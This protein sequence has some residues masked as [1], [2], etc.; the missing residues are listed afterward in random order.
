MVAHFD[1]NKRINGIICDLCGKVCIDTFEYYSG[2]FDFISVDRNRTAQGPA[3]V[4]ERFMDVDFCKDCWKELE[5]RMRVNLER[6][7][8]KG[9][10]ST[11][12]K[13]SGPRQIRQRMKP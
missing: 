6:I 3:E 1:E 7:D 10:W 9:S 4:D 8:K 2:K 13:P 11:S 5:N 12:T